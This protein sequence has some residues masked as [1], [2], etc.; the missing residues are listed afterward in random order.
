MDFT[1]NGKTYYAP[2]ECFGAAISRGLSDERQK[3]LIGKMRERGISVFVE[4][5]SA[6]YKADH[7]GHGDND[8]IDEYLNEYKIRGNLKQIP[9]TP[10]ETSKMVLTELFENTRRFRGRVPGIIDSIAI[11]YDFYTKNDITFNPID[12]ISEFN[13]QSVK[14]MVEAGIPETYVVLCYMRY[15]P[16]KC[17]AL[18]EHPDTVQ[19][20]CKLLVEGFVE[21]SES[22]TIAADWIIDHIAT[23]KNTIQKITKYSDRLTINKSDSV[24]TVKTKIANTKSY[25]EIEKIEKIYKK[26]KFKFKECTCELKNVGEKIDAG[27]YSVYIMNPDD[28]RQVLL[29]YNTTCCQTIEDAG[30]SAMMHGLLNPKAGF[31]IIEEKT[32]GII[33]VQAE[34]WELDSDTLIFDNIEYAN[35]CEISLYKDTMKKWLECSDYKNIRTGKG[36]NN[37]MY[38]GNFRLAGPA[39]PPVT[40][41]EIYV[42]SYE[43]GSDAPVLKDEEEAAKLLQMGK[44][45]NIPPYTLG[46][47]H[48]GVTYFDYVYC[49]SEKDTYWLKENGRIE[50][51][52]TNEKTEREMNNEIANEYGEHILNY[53]MAL[54][55]SLTLENEEEYEEDE[56]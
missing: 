22:K 25:K 52:F 24:D 34:V 9:L 28:E 36:Y 51:Y 30:E 45:N 47:K 40:P 26:P 42:I 41:R 43:P 48:I 2:D 10:D 27:R 6:I 46:N 37:L 15:S 7:R 17:E 55:E 14:K 44:D 29:G 4:S 20:V 23:D 11:I 31:W 3:E 35:D 12:F 5:A 49:D 32:T 38:E 19:N 21:K 53:I 54:R 13:L 1:Y 18:A 8:K 39:M 56:I 33:K 16:D 50:P